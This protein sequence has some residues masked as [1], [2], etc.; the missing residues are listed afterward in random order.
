M[1]PIDLK[2]AAKLIDFSGGQKDLESLGQQQLE[3]AVAL[4]NM[5][6]DPAIGMGY[7]ADEVGMGKTYTSLGTVALMR[8]FNPCLRVL[9]ICPS[10]NVQ[11]KWAER[12]HPSFIK[13]NVLSDQFRIRTP[14][15]NSGTP[16]ISCSNVDSLINAATTGYFGDI[17]VRMSS[18]SMGMSSD[19]ESLEK[20]LSRLRQRV[21]DTLIGP[22]DAADVH[23]KKAQVK[24]AYARAVNYL[25]PTFDLVVI[26]EAHNFKHNFDSSDRNRALSRILGFTDESGG[27]R[28]RAKAAL[29]MSATPYDLDSTQLLNQLR[30]VGKESLLPKHIIQSDRE[31]LKAHIRQFMVRRL[32]EL[33]IAGQRHTRNM[34]RQE[35]RYGNHAEVEFKTDEHKLITALVQKQVGDLLDSDRSNPS[36]QM[37]MLASFESYAQT[38]DI[39]SA[40]KEREFDGEAETQDPPEA[41]DRHVIDRISKTYVKQGLGQTLPHPKMD[42][43]SQTLATEAFRKARK[44]LVFVRRVKSVDELKAKL[45]DA[46]NTWLMRYIENLLPSGSPQAAYMQDVFSAYKQARQQ[47]D[48]DQ[49]IAAVDEPTDDDDAESVA[50][51]NDTL[52]SW[53][54]RGTQETGIGAVTGNDRQQWPTPDQVRKALTDKSALS[55]LF[56]EFNWA[57]WYARHFTSET[58]TTLLDSIPTTDFQHALEAEQG[59]ANNNTQSSFLQ[60]QIVFLRLMHDQQEAVCLDPLIEYL[61]D[62]LERDKNQPVQDIETARGLITQ[63]TIFTEFADRGLANRLFG[64]DASLAQ[65]FRPNHHPS[66]K[67]DI[68]KFEA[69]RQL[70]AQTLRTGHGMIDLYVSR[71][72]LGADNLNTARRDRWRQSFCDLL[73][74][75]LSHVGGASNDDVL[76]T[77]FSTAIE[78]FRLS[79]NLDLV[80]KNNLPGVYKI[81]PREMPRWLTGTLK[82]GG[83]IMGANGMT[84]GNRSSQARKFRMP[85]YPLV[86][87]S[88]DV[89]QEGEDLHTFCD[90][91][92]HYGLA[93]S[94]VGIEQK[95]GRVDRV[96]AFAHRRLQSERYTSGL[97]PTEDEYIQVTFPFVKQSIE[98]VQIRQLCHNLNEFIRSLHEIGDREGTGNENIDMPGQVVDRSE[99][100]DQIRDVLHSPYAPEVP[101][102][103][104]PDLLEKIERQ[105]DRTRQA[106]QNVNTLFCQVKAKL[107]DA[108]NN[109]DLQFQIT[110]ARSSGEMLVRIQSTQS[111]IYRGQ[112]KGNPTSIRE[113]QAKLYKTS[114]ARTFAIHE[115]KDIALYQDAEILVGGTDITSEQDI[116]GAFK[117]V[118]EGFD[119][120]EAH[121]LAPPFELEDVEAYLKRQFNW[122]GSVLRT[123][124]ED[125]PTLTVT[126]HNDR[127]RKQRI[128]ITACGDFARFESPVATSETVQKL[129]ADQLLDLTWLRNRRIDLVE[130][131][132]DPEQN[133]VGRTFHPRESLGLE[134]F[135]FNLFVL[136]AEADRAEYFLKESDEF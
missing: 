5:L 135:A 81:T 44:Q 40:E 22:L 43:V 29:L 67:S 91:V 99:I 39:S 30:L 69:H 72:N 50:A 132:V 41:R 57:D 33:T 97:K 110:S 59:L 121:P 34:Y 127:H 27:Y 42:Q 47:R 78:L 114:A 128:H 46:Y 8:Y 77:L 136:A 84:R 94:P 4:H 18:F 122:Q 52:F 6:A 56:F 115:D 123:D 48:R 62:S 31:T 65:A 96:N 32:N 113:L 37:G 105:S 71:I 10:A 3:G 103:K 16:S 126:F 124:A 49:D 90:S 21:P 54:F 120:T 134:E 53:F 89:F 119:S 9:Y 19:D 1:Q 51:K 12:E 64:S 74:D 108:Y 93:S 100:P 45:D 87:I 98:A 82:S 63:R 38:A 131:L 24:A 107:L 83:P 60:A 28:R 111:L 92:V 75:Q 11:E 25:L 95:T 68:H 13:H 116:R 85:G 88:T 17:F 58:L 80:I 14:E 76:N 102:A 23:E 26:D 117:R 36:F 7:L 15:G 133:L 73:S 104:F 20:H 129:N 70:V 86:L 66:I 101:E 109:R 35:W 79:E 106:V 61:A 130:F 118:L 55:G 125:E 2:A 112:L